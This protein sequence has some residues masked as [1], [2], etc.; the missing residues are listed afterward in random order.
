LVFIE[1]DPPFLRAFVDLEFTE[2]A[3]I[4]IWAKRTPGASRSEAAQLVENR[5]AW[6]ARMR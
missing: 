6:I 2:D 1:A 5:E 3:D 4:T